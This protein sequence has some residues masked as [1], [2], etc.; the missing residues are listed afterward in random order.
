MEYKENIKYL[1]RYYRSVKD[2]DLIFDFEEGFHYDFRDE[3]DTIIEFLILDLDC[4]IKNEGVDYNEQR[5]E[6]LEEFYNTNFYKILYKKK[7][8]KQLKQ[9]KQLKKINKKINKQKR[10]RTQTRSVKIK[11]LIF[12][13]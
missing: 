1:I 13:E 8:R 5:H 7:Q 6:H 11:E 10:K 12:N 2:E 4:I 9:C 3:R